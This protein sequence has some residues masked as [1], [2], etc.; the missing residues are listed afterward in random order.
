[1]RSLRWLFIS[2]GILFVLI[3]LAIAGGTAWLNS[4]VHSDAFRHEVE[5]R[6]SDSLGGP[7]QIQSIDFSLFGGVKLKGMVTQLDSNH[8]D[9]QGTLI[10]NIESVDCHCALIPLLRRQ[11]ELTGLTLQKPQIV[12]TRQ[13]S[14]PVPPSPSAQAGGAVPEAASSAPGTP[15]QF[16]LKAARI[17]EG[18]VSIRD[19]SGV[20]MA[21]L[22]G[23]VIDADTSG[24]Y[25]GNDIT[26]KVKIADLALPSN[27]H[28]TDFS[29]PFTYRT[30]AISAKPI[31]AT[32]F[33]GKLA[34]EYTL[35]ATG[36]SL[37]V[38]N[39]KGLD[40]GQLGRTANPNSTTRLS[41]SLDL[42][43][44]WRGVETGQL[45]G[46]GDLQLTDG[47]LEG[48]SVLHDL[49]SILKIKELNEPL[50]KKVTSHFLVASGQTQFSG[51]QIDG[52]V[53]SMTGGGT[54]GA[55]GGLS[56]DMVLILTPASM[57]RMPK[58]VAMFFVQQTDGSGTVAFHVGGT[59]SNPQTDLATRLFIQ[60]MKVKNVIS[61]ALNKFFK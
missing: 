48:V 27:L 53:F 35:G 4:Y 17:N 3:A 19:V 43:S 51:L 2:V 52:G 8:V 54:I 56:A 32:A 13:T 16:I 37:L 21:D 38:V 36:P 15:F 41:G 23:I 28:L 50:L 26:G 39:G 24:Y 30:G 29:S 10:A 9:G 34:G 7:V 55:D 6:A 18:S 25:N 47:K 42:Q 60:N 49:G 20:S 5:T 45:N 1:M 59:V 61:K 58:E 57:G 44:N 46:E 33:N 31:E 12:L 14:V 22:Q 40:V 11:L